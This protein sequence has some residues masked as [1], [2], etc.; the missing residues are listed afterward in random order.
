MNKNKIKAT[1]K[2]NKLIFDHFIV[3]KNS[4]NFI[5]VY[6]RHGYSKCGPLI[7]SDTTLKGAAKKAKLLEIGWMFGEKEMKDCYREQCRYCS[8]WD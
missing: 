1:W 5:G 2:D 7:T 8:A 3:C 6:H 4:D